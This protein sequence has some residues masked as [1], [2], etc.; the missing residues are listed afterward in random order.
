MYLLKRYGE[1]VRLQ[2][3]LF[4]FKGNEGGVDLEKRKL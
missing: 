4:F 2:P 3:A 1:K